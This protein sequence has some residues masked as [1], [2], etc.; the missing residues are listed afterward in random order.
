MKL[1]AL[2][3][4][5]VTVIASPVSAGTH[6]FD[7][8]GTFSI[9]NSPPITLPWIGTLALTTAADSDGVYS[10]TELTSFAFLSNVASIAIDGSYVPPV[11]GSPPRQLPPPSVTLEDGMVTSIAGQLLLSPAPFSALS[12][13][14]GLNVAIG[15]G[16]II[17]G[18][19]VAV[20]VLTP[21]PEPE[22]F[23]LML[24]GLGAVGA[25]RFSRPAPRLTLPTRPDL[26]PDTP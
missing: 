18:D 23:A 9:R 7:L 19:I 16:F 25:R 26:T 1:A 4:S 8:D 11:F 24:V 13:V 15:P 2:V 14:G 5:V 21:V 3:A 12:F 20:G 22:I 10:G 6:E 17:H